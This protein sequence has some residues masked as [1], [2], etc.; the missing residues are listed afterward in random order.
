MSL[1]A[2]SDE[3]SN[4]E[5]SAVLRWPTSVLNLEAK[6]SAARQIARLAHDGDVVGI[7]SGSAAYLA[8]RAIADRIK[9]EDITVKVVPSSYEIE[10]AAIDLGMDV[11]TLKMALP[12]WIVDGA[13]EVDPSGRVLKGRGGALFREK[14][15]WSSCSIRYLVI[16]SSKVVDRLGSKFPVPVEIHPEV[17]GLVAD[18]LKKY[19]SVVDV[20]LRN[21]GASKDGPLITEQGNLIL[22][23][24]LSEV[25]VGFHAEI[26]GIPGVIETGIFEG[27]DYQVIREEDMPMVK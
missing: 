1:G 12:S 4:L 26:K 18:V 19:E 14:V 6:Q 11:K 21:A 8:M 7:G 22:D 25:P 20:R 23:L 5:A 9:N 2:S 16:D 15:L 27:Y 24:V 10:V 17:V 3:A 13:D